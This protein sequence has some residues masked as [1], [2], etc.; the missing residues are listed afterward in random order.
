MFVPFLRFTLLISGDIEINPGPENTCNQNLSLCL[1]NLNGI[2]A[3][4]CIK[5]SILEAYITVHDFDFICVSETFLDSS[6]SSDDP[7]LSIQG[8]AMLRSDHPSNT[9]RGGVCIYYK[10]HLPFVRRDGITNLDECIVGEIKVKNSNFF[11]HLPLS[12]S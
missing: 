6:Y 10:E 2:A 5:I 1:W 8:Y 11:F 7:K 9:K 3:Y 12:L 4:N